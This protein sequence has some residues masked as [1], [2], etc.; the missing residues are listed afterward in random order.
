MI[1]SKHASLQNERNAVSKANDKELGVLHGKLAKS[2]LAAL[3]ASEEAKVLLDEHAHELPDPVI[4]FLETHANANPSLL[5][6][7]AKF[8]KDNN[9]T[10]AIESSEE[11]SA[12]EKHLKNKKRVSVGNVIPIT[13]DE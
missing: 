4:R 13:D 6:A 1:T 10:A 7:V 11:M 5:T 3:D 2:M 9:I 12:L 8:L